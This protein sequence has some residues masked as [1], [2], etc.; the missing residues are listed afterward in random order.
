MNKEELFLKIREILVEQFDVEAANVSLDANLYDE[1]QIDS[2]D[3]VDLLVQLKELTGEKI[4][5]E[6]FR[7]VRTIG[8]VLDA[9]TVL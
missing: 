7:E 8:D 4:A 1:L 6:K 9:L 3:A 2:I 5:P